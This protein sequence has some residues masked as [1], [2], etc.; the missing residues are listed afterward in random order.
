LACLHLTWSDFDEAMDVMAEHIKEDLDAIHQKGR[1][2]YLAGQPRG[3]LVLAIALSHRL[4]IPLFMSF[5]HMDDQ[6]SIVW[7]DD[8]LDTGKTANVAVDAFKQSSVA[9]LPYVWVSKHPERNS[10]PYVL[11]TFKNTWIVFPWEDADRAEVDR[12]N[13]LQRRRT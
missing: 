3:G 13:F 10:I 2:V 11:P 1:N 6:D 12:Q 8:I 5:Q 4:D 7:I 9:F